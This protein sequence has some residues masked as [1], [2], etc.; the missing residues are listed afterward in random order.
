MLYGKI[1]V[2]C[3][4]LPDMRLKPPL[5]PRDPEPSVR[6]LDRRRARASGQHGGAAVPAA[7]AAAAAADQV[8]VACTLVGNY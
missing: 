2:A 3:L 4:S 7:F 1:S 8:A 5:P 6:R